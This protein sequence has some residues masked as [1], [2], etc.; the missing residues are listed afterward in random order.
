[1]DDKCPKCGET[2]SDTG[3]CRYPK[4]PSLVRWSCGTFTDDSDG[5]LSQSD[6][7]R[8]RKLVAEVEGL[9]AIVDR[10]PV[11]ADGVLAPP[12]TRVYQVDEFGRVHVEVMIGT[13]GNGP[14]PRP[15]GGVWLPS[16]SYSTPEAAKAARD[17]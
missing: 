13:V 5:Y 9:R 17:K 10:I 16:D 11:L 2:K 15:N 6:A 7:C 3:M 14:I 4:R 1:M 8:V 12:G